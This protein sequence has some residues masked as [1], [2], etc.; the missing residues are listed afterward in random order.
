[1]AVPR[2]RQAATNRP[3]KRRLRGLRVLLLLGLLGVL[4][5]V[6]LAVRI[7]LTGERDER[8]RADVIIV[9]GAA[10]YNGNPSPVY[11]ARLDHALHLY[12]AGY[13]PR[14]F[15][16][17]GKRPGDRFTEAGAGRTYALRHGV[18]PAAILMETHGRTTWQSMQTAAAR[19]R[20]LHLHHALLVSDPFHAFRLR[21]M[22]RDLG[23]RAGVSP[24]AHSRI[25]SGPMRARYVAREMVVYTLY[26][27]FG[28]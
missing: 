5:L 14:L 1:M 25:R 18:P 9:L 28:V 12:Q 11:Q 13:A 17:G 3:R 10:Q 15:F 16:T 8:A 26:R 23:M 21:R 2:S 6:S 20:A 7:T 22:A 19:M 27:L 24:A 4:Y